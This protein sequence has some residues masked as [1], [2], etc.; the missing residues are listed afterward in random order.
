MEFILFLFF[1][2]N[3]FIRLSLSFVKNKETLPK[4]RRKNLKQNVRE[5]FLQMKDLEVIQKTVN[6]FLE[7]KVIKIILK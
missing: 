3:F 7:R 4:D 6:L 2:T 5:I 1:K